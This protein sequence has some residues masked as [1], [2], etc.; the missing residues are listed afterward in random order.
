MRRGAVCVLIVV[1]TAAGYFVGARG[2]EGSGTRATRD[3]R[4]EHAERDLGVLATE[5]PRAEGEVSAT[6]PAK[7][8]PQPAD[9]AVTPAA[10]ASVV[11]D[12]ATFVGPSSPLE[13][14]WRDELDRGGAMGFLR[15][16]E[17]ERHPW[18]TAASEAALRV[19]ADR[20]MFT[21]IFEAKATGP[22]VDGPTA[23]WRTLADGTTLVYPE[24]VFAVGWTPAMHKRFPRD[25]T[26][27]GK[28]MDRT[29]LRVGSGMRYK[30]GEIHGLA[31]LDLTADCGRDDLLALD[32][33]ATLRLERCR[34]LRV[35]TVCRADAAALYAQGCEFDGG[36]LL[37]TDHKGLARL[38]GCRIRRTIESG[39]G[40]I[41][42][43]FARC[44]FVDAHPN[45]Q[46]N[47]ENCRRVRLEGCRF[48]VVASMLPPRPLASINPAWQD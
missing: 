47:L 12:T 8:A 43:L 15:A 40:D 39:V 13:V 28:G 33:L 14:L 17:R 42:C 41:A 46:H 7:A 19:L 37:R 11:I 48:E 29:L 35:D 27:K 44:T 3:T 26:L 30:V 18:G 2:G 25:L 32:G 1:A 20:E 21:R 16:L 31:L 45:L 9:G 10:E 5:P 4:I 6:A 23:D 24:G 22:V 34:V 36:E 38:D